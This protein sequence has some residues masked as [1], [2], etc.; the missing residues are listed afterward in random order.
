MANNAQTNKVEVEFGRF[1]I[2]YMMKN[3]P[4]GHPDIVSLKTAKDLGVE[5]AEQD[6]YCIR[7]AHEDGG[8][9]K[10]CQSNRLI[11]EHQ[12][13]N[14]KEIQEYIA[15]ANTT[16]LRKKGKCIGV[17]VEEDKKPDIFFFNE[18]VM[19]SILLPVVDQS[20]FRTIAFLKEEK[21]II[22]HSITF[23]SKE[24][25]RIRLIKKVYGDGIE[26][27]YAIEGES[28]EIINHRI[29]KVFYDDFA[30]ANYT[31]FNRIFQTK[32]YN[33]AEMRMLRWRVWYV[34]NLQQKGNTS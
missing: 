4:Q 27:S 30:S 16:L 19:V 17:F 25:M 28:T 12:P 22:D 1:R 33:E 32:Y 13:F 2:A 18:E 34:Q 15:K 31:L 10:S 6:A 26:S 24:R 29:W 23:L 7:V 5:D 8:G 20:I 9:V 3:N 14:L 21:A 11:L